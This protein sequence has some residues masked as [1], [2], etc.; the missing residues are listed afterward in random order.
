MVGWSGL[1]RVEYWLRPDAGK[2]GQLA[3]D[4]PAWQT[5]TLAAVHASSRRRRTGAA[6]CPKA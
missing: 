4:D 5:A 2:H 3:D 1:K 6:A